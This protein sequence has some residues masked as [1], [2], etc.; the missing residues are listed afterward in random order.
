MS[1]FMTK[2]MANQHGKIEGTR[3]ASSTKGQSQALVW[4]FVEWRVRDVFPGPL[5]QRGF[6][7]GKWSHLLGSK[8]WS[9]RMTT[10]AESNRMRG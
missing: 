4:K 7:D 1:A 8:G 3:Y 6:Q 9:D 10:P 5:A 2:N